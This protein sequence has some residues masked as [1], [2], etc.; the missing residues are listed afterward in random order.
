M[1]PGHVYCFCA[2]ILVYA[3]PDPVIED[4]TWSDVKQGFNL[5]T[6]SA[7]ICERTASMKKGQRSSSQF[8]KERI[9]DT[10][11]GNLGPRANSKHEERP[12]KLLLKISHHQPFDTSLTCFHQCTSIKSSLCSMSD[13]FSEHRCHPCDCVAQIERRKHVHIHIRTLTFD[14]TPYMVAELGHPRI[15]E[16]IE[17][18]I[19]DALIPLI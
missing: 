14:R 13:S 9:Q 8:Q 11:E 16:R 17:R 15:S 3:N 5:L 18:L 2:R 19:V 10:E 6:T 12:K 7:S 4:Q 1:T